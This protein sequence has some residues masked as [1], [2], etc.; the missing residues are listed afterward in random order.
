MGALSMNDRK[1]VV[2]DAGPTTYTAPE[3]GKLYCFANDLWR[4]YFN[5]SGMVKLTVNRLS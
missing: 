1:T 2:L 5:N 4:F 3:D